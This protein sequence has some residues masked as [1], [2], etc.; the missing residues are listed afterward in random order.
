MGLLQLLNQ[1]LNSATEAMN[2]QTHPID[3]L[4]QFHDMSSLS[5]L[6]VDGVRMQLTGSYFIHA[7]AKNLSQQLRNGR[8]GMLEYALPR[9][10]RKIDLT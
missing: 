2:H 8:R 1:T 9:A 7:K 4:L 3:L 6:N 5:V 10:V